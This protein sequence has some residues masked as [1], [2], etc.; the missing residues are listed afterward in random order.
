MR[1]EITIENRSR[2]VEIARH[3]P[4]RGPETY[5]GKTQDP[6]KPKHHQSSIEI[7]ERQP[8]RLVVSIGNKIYAISQLKRSPVSVT[9]VVNG[10]VVAAELKYKIGQGSSHLQA[11]PVSEFMT[12][13]L[14]ARVV[15]VNARPGELLNQGACLIVLEAMK[16]EVQIQAPK[17]CTVREI[18]VRE[19]ENIEKGKKMIWLKFT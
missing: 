14:P 9:F 4:K 12:S 18:Y 2:E 7:L 3:D 1:Y 17:D 6:S 10:R 16:M 11:P 8:R 5:A 13:T 15:K 19:G